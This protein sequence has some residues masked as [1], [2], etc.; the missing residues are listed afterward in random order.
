MNR[1]SNQI[2][3]RGY[4]NNYGSRRPDNQRQ[5]SFSNCGG[6]YDRRRT[7]NFYNHNNFNS[8]NYQTGRGPQSHYQQSG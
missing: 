4:H 2:R 5:Q 1:R 6:L 7:G 3:G 8:N